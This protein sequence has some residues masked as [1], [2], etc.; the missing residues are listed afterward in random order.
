VSSIRVT[1]VPPSDIAPRHIT[2]A[3]IG[4]EIP[5]V[6]EKFLRKYP[7]S[8]FK[9]GSSNNNGYIVVRTDAIQAL[10]EAGQDEAAA[11][12]ENRSLGLYLEFKRDACEIIWPKP[13]EGSQGIVLLWSAAI[14]IVADVHE[15]KVSLRFQTNGE[16]ALGDEEV[17]AFTNA[18]MILKSRVN[19]EWCN[20]IPF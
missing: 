12:W 15:F 16:V 7:L 2:E 3:W 6:T 8:G 9:A 4:V 14:S 17:K 18:Y 1:K 10:R 5:I 13:L 20:D 11:Y 19:M